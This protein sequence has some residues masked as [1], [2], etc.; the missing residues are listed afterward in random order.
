M[1]IFVKKDSETEFI[2]NA[3]GEWIPY[4]NGQ[5]EKEKIYEHVNRKKFITGWYKTVKKVGKNCY[6]VRYYKRI[7]AEQ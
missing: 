7:G 2:K 3:G 5:I 1:Y 4:L 6:K